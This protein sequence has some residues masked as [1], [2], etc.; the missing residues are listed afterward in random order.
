MNICCRNDFGAISKRFSM[1]S[2]KS[3]FGCIAGFIEVSGTGGS[4]PFL[5]GSKSSARLT[6]RKALESWPLLCETPVE[7]GTTSRFVDTSMQR[8]EFCGDSAFNDAL[9]DLREW[10]TARAAAECPPTRCF[11]AFA[12]GARTFTRQCTQA[13]RRNFLSS[14]RLVDRESG[15]I[16]AQFEMGAERRRVST[17]CEK[18]SQCELA[19]RPCRGGRKSDLT[20]DLR[21]D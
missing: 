19:G 16:A 18:W 17:C 15:R 21:L 11:R 3:G 6:V 7:G 2:G 8:L 13:S 20:C 12:T 9:S 14:S 4:P 5:I 10:P 1:N